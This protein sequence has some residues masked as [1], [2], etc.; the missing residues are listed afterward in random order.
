MV[1]LIIS[2]PMALQSGM[3]AEARLK[4]LNRLS[5]SNDSFALD[6][7]CQT[8]G[9]ISD[10]LIA[11]SAF[12]Y[13]ESMLENCLFNPDYECSSATTQF[14]LSMFL[15]YSNKVTEVCPI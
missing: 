12:W 13:Y 1:G 5:E 4:G 8:E 2:L 9:M 7:N 10:C 11:M 3:S 6:D 14:Y 15:Y